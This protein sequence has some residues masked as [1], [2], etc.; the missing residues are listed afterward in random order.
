MGRAVKENVR[1]QNVRLAATAAL[2]TAG[3]G[4]PLLGAGAPGKGFAVL[5]GM[6]MSVQVSGDQIVRAPKADHAPAHEK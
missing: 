1:D 5:A 6:P 3:G 2:A 4:G